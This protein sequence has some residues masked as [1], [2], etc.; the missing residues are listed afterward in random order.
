MTVVRGQWQW[1][2]ILL[3]FIFM[4][5]LLQYL[6]STSLSAGGPK[7]ISVKMVCVKISDNFYY[8]NYKE[9]FQVDTTIP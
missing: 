7:M 2:Y 9:L 1:C 5:F 4:F 3:L 8:K 6:P